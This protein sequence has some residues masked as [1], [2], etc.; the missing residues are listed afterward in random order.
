MRYEEEPEP[1]PDDDGTEGDPPSEPD[2]EETP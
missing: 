2:D 1:A